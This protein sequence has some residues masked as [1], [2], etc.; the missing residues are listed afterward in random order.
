M[1]TKRA[2]T[3]EAAMRIKQLYAEV[4]KWGRKKHSQMSIAKSMGVGETTV[5]RVIHSSGA[6]MALPELATDKDAEASAEEFKKRFPELA[7]GHSKL[8]ELV[9]E[10]GK[11]DRMLDEMQ[12]ASASEPMSKGPLDE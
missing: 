7:P 2:L 3:P 6:Y 12:D 10:R 11:G 4:D 1:S 9:E 5:Y 8:A